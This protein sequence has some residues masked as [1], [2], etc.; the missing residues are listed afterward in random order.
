MRTFTNVVNWFEIPV[1]NMARAKKFYET[2]FETALFDLPLNNELKMALFPTDG[3]G[4]GG[5]LCEHPNFYFPGNHGPLIYL[6]ADPDLAP[7]LA[8]V[9][10]AGGK[11]LIE[12]RMISPEHGFMAVLEDSEGNRIALRSTQ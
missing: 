1:K 3:N 6:N 2:I 12:K 4:V 8:K 11:V 10:G 9:A 5:A 7:V